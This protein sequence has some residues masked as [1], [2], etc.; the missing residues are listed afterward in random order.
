MGKD[1]VVWK[2]LASASCI[3]AAY[4]T[5]LMGIIALPLN[6]PTMGGPVAPPPRDP[7]VGGADC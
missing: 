4:S 2:M 1:E 6:G 3:H 5:L 7:P